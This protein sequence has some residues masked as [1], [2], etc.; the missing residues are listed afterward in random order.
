MKTVT[1]NNTPVILFSSI[2]E[3]PLERYRAMQNYMLQDSGVGNTMA[4]I[5]K[6][7]HHA[8]IFLSNNKVKECSDELTNLRYNFFSMIN[9]IDYKTKSF[10]CLVKQVNSLLCD[11]ITTDGLN[12]TVDALKVLQINSEEIEELWND[13]KKNWMLN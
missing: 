11:D 7:L 5:D 9:G 12:A 2:K 1:I 8:L 4:D 10:A 13:V 6:H 3:L